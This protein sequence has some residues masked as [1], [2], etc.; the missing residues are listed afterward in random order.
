LSKI[1]E[2]G[3]F[4]NK[5]DSIICK[6]SGAGEDTIS[7]AQ[8][9]I[10]LPLWATVKNSYRLAWVNYGYF[11]KISYAWLI[12]SIPFLAAYYWFTLPALADLTCADPSRENGQNPFTSLDDTFHSTLVLSPIT[13]LFILLT[14]S[15]A[16][17]WHRLI[18]RNEKT[19]NKFY[20]CIDN[21]VW[22]YFGVGFCFWLLSYLPTLF[23]LMAIHGTPFAWIVVFI[24]SIALLLITTR[25]SV[26]LPAKALGLPEVSVKS[27]WQKTR[28]NFWRIFIGYFFCYLPTAIVSWIIMFSP[29][30]KI[31]CSG[32]FNTVVFGLF[33]HVL[34]ILISLPVGLS[35]LSLSF[36]HF[37]E[38]GTNPISE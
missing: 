29:L 2:A 1:E 38:S 12:L 16:V 36:K 4:C 24:S 20:L 25:V 13:I 18:L 3:I 34:Y 37:F 35:F 23:T 26:I 6:L 17:A 31:M 10:K 30:Q 22:N 33:Q 14:A 28:W 27:V 21:A 5:P 11:L 32:N 15:I 9:A 7:M 19:A 8:T